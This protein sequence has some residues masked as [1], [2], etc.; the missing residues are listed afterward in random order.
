MT[1]ED[2]FQS[3]L[4][5]PLNHLIHDLQAS[6]ALQI[7]VFLKIDSIRCAGRVE[8]LVAVRQPNRIEARLHH[9]VEHGVEAAGP[10]PLWSK[11][12]RLHAE[13]V[14][15]REVHHITIGVDDVAAVS[16]QWPS[17]ERGENGRFRS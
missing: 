9:L 4:T 3:A 5:R 12:A 14:D 11:C 1:V 6:Q 16:P 2:H 15:A 17:T 10:Q 7:S 13:P 8:Q